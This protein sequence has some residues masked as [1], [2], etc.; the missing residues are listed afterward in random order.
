[1]KFQSLKEWI[2]LNEGGEAIPNSRPITW[3]EAQSLYSWIKKT[4]SPKLGIEPEDLEVIG[5]YGKK[6]EGQ[7]HG[8]LDIA[9]SAES[10]AERNGLGKD[11]VLD[12][13]N[14]AL[15]SMGFETKKMTG[16]KQVSAGIPIPGT[17]DIAQVDF[18]L[19]PGLDWSRFIYHSPDF[20]KG[21]S[22]YKG[23]YRNALLMAIIT[24]SSKEILKRTP[25]GDVEELETNVLRY[26][27]GI[28]RAR[29]SFMGK[30][31]LVKTGQLLRDFDKFVTINPQE[32]TELAVGKGYTPQS[33]ST[34]ERLWHIVTR[35]NFIHSDKL[36][37]ILLKFAGNLKSM[38]IPYPEEAI[39]MYPDIF[40]GGIIKEGLDRLYEVG[41]VMAP[42]KFQ[43]LGEV[44]EDRFMY[45]FEIN[46]L[47]YQSIFIKRENNDWGGDLYEYHFNTKEDFFSEKPPKILN[48]GDL[49]KVMATNVA[50]IK[51]FQKKVNGSILIVGKTGS[52]TDNIEKFENRLNLYYRYFEKNRGDNKL[53]TGKNPDGSIRYMIIF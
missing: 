15:L 5:S 23:V 43:Y 1:M 17:S 9:V 32:V 34:F 10:L 6:I 41:E 37:D 39:E 47:S 14:D 22:K 4:I 30:K 11:Q 3:D 7:T 49:Y 35:D 29:K 20:R 12:F 28:W 42:A 8:D 18:M 2:S 40:S 16:F 38:G 31:G 21:E 52:D 53:Y 46:G 48:R 45:E 24:E 50:I 19:S 27:E 13:V 36:D 25:E 51:E 33:I 26:P 44:Q